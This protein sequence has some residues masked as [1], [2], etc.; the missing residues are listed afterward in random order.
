MHCRSTLLFWFILQDV[1]TGMSWTVPSVLDEAILL[2]AFGSDARYLT[3]LYGHD[4]NDEYTSYGILGGVG[5][6]E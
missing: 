2:G 1:D 4:D 5:S 6:K 3:T